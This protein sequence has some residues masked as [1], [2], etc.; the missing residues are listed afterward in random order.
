MTRWI[1]VLFLV[2][3]CFRPSFDRPACPSGEC[4]SGLVCSEAQICEAPGSGADIPAD[5]AVE[6]DATIVVDAA[7]DGAG[8]PTVMSARMTVSICATFAE[9]ITISTTTSVDTGRSGTS[10]PAGLACAQLAAGSPDVCALAARSIIIAVDA[11][12]AARG[13]RPLVLLGHT[14][15]IEGTIDVAGHVGGILAAGADLA[16]C[17]TSGAIPMGNGGGQGGTFSA[18][19]GGGGGKGG[20]SNDIGG[21]PHPTITIDALRGGCAGGA[22]NNGVDLNRIGHGGGAV[23]IAADADGTITLGAEGMINASGSGG[24][25]GVTVTERRGGYGGGSGGLIVLTAPTITLSPTAAIFADGGGGGGGGSTVQG[26][27]GADPTGPGIGGAGGGP[28]N[29]GAGGAGFP[30]ESRAGT[31]S[32]NNSIGGGGGG[33]GA[34]TIWT[35]DPNLVDNPNISPR[36]EIVAR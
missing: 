30:V 3:A 29:Q 9:Q 18:S 1:A 5:V 7:P 13:T 4:P 2:P 6:P 23:W 36:P 14:V 10:V 27:P 11:T 17:D 32:T 16:G 22:S 24:S 20:D 21:A 8:C 28:A 12:L 33:G 19:P 15:D 25:G 34:G 35:T 31:S 26:S